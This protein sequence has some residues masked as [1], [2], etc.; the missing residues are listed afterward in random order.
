MCGGSENDLYDPKRY[1]ALAVV[2]DIIIVP[3]QDPTSLAGQLVF[4]NANDHRSP[5]ATHVRFTPAGPR[6]FQRDLNLTIL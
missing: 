1:G 6:S 2:R 4:F 5:V 3:E